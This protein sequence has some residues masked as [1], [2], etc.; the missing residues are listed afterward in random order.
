[1]EANTSQSSPQE[2][3]RS[4]LPVPLVSVGRNRATDR[5]TTEL[6]GLAALAIGP[7]PS[8]TDVP[9]NPALEDD[10]IRLFIDLTASSITGGR[11]GAR[12]AGETRRRATR[13]ARAHVRAQGR[14]ICAPT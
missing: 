10:S 9:N 2:P 14:S 8:S 5:Y 11:G 3:L 13:G 7:T 4:L 12:V 6:L 1:M